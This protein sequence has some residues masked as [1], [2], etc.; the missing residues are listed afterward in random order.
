MKQLFETFDDFRRW[1]N[2]RF[3]LSMNGKFFGLLRLSERGIDW[4]RFQYKLYKLLN[5]YY[6]KPTDDIIS[7]R[8]H[9]VSL[10]LYNR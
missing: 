1:F 10:K 3:S 5:G 9:G 6:R 8:M 2:Q 4:K 7:I